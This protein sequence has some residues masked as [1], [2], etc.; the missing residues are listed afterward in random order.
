MTITN[1]FYAQPM[2]FL[3]LE[4][5]AMFVIW[6]AAMLL[7]RG[8]V[9][10]IVAFTC[11]VI[12]IALI[13]F[14][15]LYGRSRK[16]LDTVPD[17]LP[18]ISFVKSDLKSVVWRSMF[19]NILLFIPLGLSMPFVLSERVKHN[20]LVTV[21]SCAALSVLIELVQLA[22]SMGKF[23]VNDMIMNTLGAALGTVSFLLVS[24]ILKKVNKRRE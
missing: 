8:K 11:T 5:L 3:Y 22:F 12:S 7:L 2:I 16:I 15:T 10:K 13:L 1:N 21:L 24:L 23:E 19:L 4:S 14:V 20:V 18:L 17:F 6:T 9:R